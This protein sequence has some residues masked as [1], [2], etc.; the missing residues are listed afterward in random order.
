MTKLMERTAQKKSS[1]GLDVRKTLRGGLVSS[2][3]RT[4]RVPGWPGCTATGRS[5]PRFGWKLC[6]S[7]CRMSRARSISWLQSEQS[8]WTT[9]SSSLHHCCSCSYLRRDQKHNN[10]SFRFG[11]VDL[12]HQT[13]GGAEVAVPRA[14][15]AVDHLRGRRALHS[16][17]TLR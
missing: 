14:A 7:C 8:Q 2:S 4:V 10:V 6:P 9:C 12:Q 16:D 15:A 1:F 13:Q 5:L 11:A 3:S 17:E